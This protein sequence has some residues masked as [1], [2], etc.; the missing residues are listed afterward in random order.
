MCGAV[1]TSGDIANADSALSAV[2]TASSA[3]FGVGRWPQSII[4]SGK[5][6][7]FDHDKGCLQ[8]PIAYTTYD[9]LIAIVVVVQTQ[10]QKLGKKTHH[11]K[12][13]GT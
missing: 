8:T 11:L 5:G 3:S 7:C 4:H 12:P 1:K 2:E 9:D 10:N 13:N 6:I